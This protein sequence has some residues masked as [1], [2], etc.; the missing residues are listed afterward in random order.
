MQSKRCKH[1]L[2]FNTGLLN[3][4]SESP[5]SQQN[6][7]EADELSIM[8]YFTA[9][10]SRQR[11]KLYIHLNDSYGGKSVHCLSRSEAEMRPVHPKLLP[12]LQVGLSATNSAAQPTVLIIV[13]G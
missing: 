6:I 1:P 9:S 11:L 12:L 2:S 4:N 8:R 13:T 10:W 3:I 5:T 7:G